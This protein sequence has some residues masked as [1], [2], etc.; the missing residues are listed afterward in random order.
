MIW[1][2]LLSVLGICGALSCATGP[3]RTG[4]FREIP[5][6]S[7]E[8]ATPL[9]LRFPAASGYRIRQA[10]GNR[11]GR[12]F[13][14]VDPEGRAFFPVGKDSLRILDLSLMK[15]YAG[16]RWPFPGYVPLS[17]EPG[18]PEFLEQEWIKQ[19]LPP[20][21]DF[22]LVRLDEQ[23]PFPADVLNRALQLDARELTYRIASKWLYKERSHSS[24]L[25]ITERERESFLIRIIHDYYS[26]GTLAVRKRLPDA[27]V[28]SQ[29]HRFEDFELAPLRDLSLQF[30][31]VLQIRY[32]R[33]ERLTEV[34]LQRL[35]ERLPRPVYFKDVPPGTSL[36]GLLPLIDHPQ[37]IGWD[38]DRTRPWSTEEQEFVDRFERG[39]PGFLGFR[40]PNLIASPPGL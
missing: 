34:A 14:L 37:V 9:A 28:V 32:P 10:P 33:G 7:E 31:D 36:K 21:A 27:L 23:I 5:S 1:I 3:R 18:F 30:C 38:W 39:L 22:M 6:F 8:A 29:V 11:E 26:F 12:K 20:P 16:K 40:F 15:T 2:R 35:V 4:P 25:G 19:S 13:W 17:L 24:T